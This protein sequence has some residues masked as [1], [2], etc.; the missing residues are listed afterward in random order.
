MSEADRTA[1]EEPVVYG[2]QRDLALFLLEHIENAYNT[3]TATVA[4][5]EAL[6]LIARAAEEG[7]AKRLKEQE[8][9]ELS[10]ELDA[11]VGAEE[12]EQKALMAAAAEEDEDRRLHPRVRTV[13]TGNVVL[14]ITW[15]KTLEN[16][17][18]TCRRCGTVYSDHGF[19]AF[20]AAVYVHA[21]ACGES[22]H[23]IRDHRRVRESLW[24][25]VGADTG[26]ADT[27]Q[28]LEARVT[29]L[30]TAATAAVGEHRRELE[31]ARTAHLD[32]LAKVQEE[33]GEVRAKDGERI[34]AL[35]TDL[36]T[37]KRSTQTWQCAAGLLGLLAVVLAL[38]V[39]F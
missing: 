34:G 2:D 28:A 36:K 9:A 12:P 10:D 18:F 39:I 5:Q 31:A 1:S 6:Q 33:V 38:A 20:L 15:P 13:Y 26:W 19:G 32:S 11:E 16:F 8:V 21:H 30:Q 24:K 25:Q 17:V 3:G 4:H 23:G 22:R 7:Y 35:E 27:A 14:D 29:E 37:A